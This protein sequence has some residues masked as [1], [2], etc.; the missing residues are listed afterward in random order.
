MKRVTV[1]CLSAIVFTACQE[2]LEP[3]S[4]SAEPSPMDLAVIVG[5]AI[6]DVIDLGTL[7]GPSSVAYSINDVGQVVG[8]S[9]TAMGEEHAFLW[10]NGVMTDL[11]TL[12]GEVS[13]ARS[14][15]NAG[16]VVGY[17]DHSRAFLWENGELTE[18]EIGVHKFG[19][20]YAINEAGQIVGAFNAPEAGVCCQ[21]FLWQN[22]LA[23][24]LGTLPGFSTNEAYAVNDLGWVVGGDG[25]EGH[26]FV[27]HNDVMTD[28]GTLVG[29]GGY[30][31]AWGING[32]GQVVGWTWA[33]GEGTT[34]THAFL[35]QSGVMRDLGTLWDSWSIARDI[36][37]AGQVV[38]ES[39]G[40]AFFWEDGVVT[41]LGTLDERLASQAWAINELGHVV[42]QSSR[43]AVLWR[44]IDSEEVMD[45]LEDEI[46]DLVESGALAPGAA[47][48][49]QNRVKIATAL[50]NDGKTDAALH[51]IEAFY[52]TI[53][54]MINAGDIAVTQGQSLLSTAQAAIS[55]LQS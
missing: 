40:R 26:A 15:N 42:G 52:E 47:G 27:W 25:P 3:S 14:I 33:P 28:L 10:E 34:L 2:V 54:R 38:G 44:P 45:V 46:A 11:G 32:A 13:T 16:Q 50:L 18:L 43:H 8:S 41:D 37:D 53:E 31:A 48:G 9:L 39:A 55:Q 36:N 19:W 12:G 29:P 35:W 4:I 21:P 17:S 6:Y 20:P 1:L 22:G 7:G 51:Q 23:T 5:D 49:L 24:N 30:S